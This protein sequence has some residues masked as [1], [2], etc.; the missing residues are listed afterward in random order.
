[1]LAL[2]P[3]VPVWTSIFSGTLKLAGGFSISG[4]TI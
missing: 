3:V 1:L 4:V 2:I